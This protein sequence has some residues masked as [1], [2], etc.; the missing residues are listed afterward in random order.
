MRGY[1]DCMVIGDDKLAVRFGSIQP[2][3]RFEALLSEFKSLFVEKEWEPNL[4]CWIVPI[5]YQMFLEKFC[6]THSLE[7]YWR[8]K[9]R[10]PIAFG[11]SRQGQWI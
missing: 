6:E 2:R 11:K 1:V 5:S 7:L 8:A 3:L 9:E 10:A 4:K